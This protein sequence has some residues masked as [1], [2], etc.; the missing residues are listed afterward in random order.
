VSSHPSRSLLS[1]LAV[2]AIALSLHLGSY[3]L[4]D[5]DE[6]RNAA[7][8]RE[9]SETNDYAVPHLNRLPYLDKPI[10]YFAAEAAVMEILGPTEFAARLPAYLFT[11]ATALAV[12]LFG[13]RLWDAERG[14]VAAI[15]FLSM[16]LTLAFAR[17]VIFDSAL[18]LC[19]TLATIAFY[20]AVEGEPAERRPP[21]F[22][23]LVAWGA[24]GLGILT[25]GPV[26][27][28]LPLLVAIP[29]SIWRRRFRSLWSWGGLIVFIAVISP[30]LYAMQ[31]AL[32]DFLQYALITETME[33]VATKKLQRTGPPWYFLP[34]LIGGALPWSLVLPFAWTREAKAQRDTPSPRL[35]LLL[36]FAIPF[37]FFSI[38]QSKRP[39]YIV[40]LMVPLALLVAYEWSSERWGRGARVAAGVMIVLGAILL[41]GPELPVWQKMKPDLAPAARSTA[42]LLGGSL[43]VA[44]VVAWF[45]RNRIARLAALA[46]PIAL[47][48]LT[49]HPI[50]T[51]IAERRSARELI[52]EM[53]PYVGAT[54][55]VVGVEAFTGS[56]AFYLDKPITVVSTDGSEYTSNYVIRR[57]SRF[58]NADGSTLKT[59]DAF[60]TSL[61]SCCKP[62]IYIIRDDDPEHQRTLENLGMR[63]IAASA[64]YFAYG[65]WT[66]PHTMR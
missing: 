34:Y 66:G 42:F 27:L 50:M 35:F 62:R 2:V 44:G 63:R 65:P 14:T 58:A 53:Q 39:Q 31:K 20:L 19:V 15:A 9:M 51:V 30:W 12:F 32:G 8:G 37:L 4:L 18:A 43:A 13:R 48:P 28:L 46:L 11:L 1:L 7:V 57:Y 60:G 3:P 16:P 23:R 24:I 29:Y 47:I 26:A 38:S 25:K 52:A 55:D 54:T 21:S 40:P 59:I 49:S 61:M 56:M 6:G 33:R 17:I 36:W 10:V 22:W 41:L 5:A 45:A 64:H